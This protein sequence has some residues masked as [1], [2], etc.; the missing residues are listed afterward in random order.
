ML[1]ILTRFNEIG[2]LAAY[3][4]SKIPTRFEFEDLDTYCP[5]SRTSTTWKVTFQLSGCP[6]FLQNIVRILWFGASIFIRHP[7]VSRRLQ[8]LQ[9][10]TAARCGYTDAQLRGPGDLK[11]TELG[12][13]N[14]EDFVKP[15][16]SVVEMRRMAG[17]RL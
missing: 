6:I 7:T 17:E 8:Y 12:L 11:V 9:C 2:R 15:F 1:Q 3:L 5:I 4:K 10:A 13:Q 14:V 16:S